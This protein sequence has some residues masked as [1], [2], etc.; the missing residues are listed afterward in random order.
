MRLT[1]QG[2]EEYFSSYDVRVREFL[3]DIL[4]EVKKQEA[5]PNN[6]FGR[7]FELMAAQLQLY[8]LSRDQ[9]FAL[10]DFTSEDSYKRLS[11]SP[12]VKIMNDAHKEVIKIM[13]DFGLSPFSKA[14]IKRLNVGADDESAE[15]LLNN[16]IN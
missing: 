12:L 14:K 8:Y 15:A 10:K 9:L 2:I 4:I 16:L 7:M 11:K 3:Q 6:Y 5:E 13:N 1:K